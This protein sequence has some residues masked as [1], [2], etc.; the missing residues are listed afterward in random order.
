[1]DAVARR[2]ARRRR[3][4]V[5]SMGAAL[6]SRGSSRRA[7]GGKAC[8]RARAPGRRHVFRRFA[9]VRVGDRYRYHLDGDR[10]LPDPVSRYQPDGVHGPSQIVHP[11][12]FRWTDREWTGLD[13]RDIGIYELH[14]GTFS[15]E[16]T[17]AGVTARLEPLA[18]WA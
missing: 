5:S 6:R 11:G 3:H 2:L 15:P 16:G 17:F 4:R 7:P 13:L 10:L 18:T 12:S 1:M 8:L 9:D 14:V